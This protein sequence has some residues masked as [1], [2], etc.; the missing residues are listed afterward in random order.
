MQPSVLFVLQPLCSFTSRQEKEQSTKRMCG[1]MRTEVLW[2]QQDVK[3]VSVL[4]EVNS[5]V[6]QQRR[7]E[8]K[9]SRAQ[10]NRITCGLRAHVPKCLI[11]FYSTGCL[12]IH[13][14][15]VSCVSRF[16][17]TF[18]LCCRSCQEGEGWCTGKTAWL[19]DSTPLSLLSCLWKRIHQLLKAIPA[20]SQSAANT[21]L[22]MK[23]SLSLSTDWVLAAVKG[24][25]RFTN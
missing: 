25:W 4:W 3:G 14:S 18:H 21:E 17:F 10:E 19:M 8:I 24:F 20:S 11:S 23:H 12:H 7:A 6:K 9:T 2:V 5:E 16:C 1:L 13:F 15:A 22:I